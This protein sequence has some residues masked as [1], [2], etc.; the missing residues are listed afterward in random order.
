MRRADGLWVISRRGFCGGVAS[1]LGLALVDCTDG[2][3][4]AIQ[5]GGLGSSGER[6]DAGVDTGTPIDSGPG[7][8]CPAS[9]TTDV[10]AP[11]AFV[12]GKPV[13]V[14]SGNFF[15]VRDSGGLYALTARCTHEGVTVEDTGTELLC[16]RHRATFTYDGDVT[17]GPA[18][19]P[20]VH[21]EMC[22]LSNGHVGVVVSHTVS[23]AQR[24]LA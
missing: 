6:T 14:A 10:G 19:V 1:C 7:A 13:Y 3:L 8:S 17:N 21:Y 20:L 24:L 18:F 9:G 22:T 4:S 15:V 11:G 23:K 16:R 12:A 5:T 2:N